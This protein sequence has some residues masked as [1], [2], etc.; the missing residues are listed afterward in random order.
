MEKI[1]PVYFDTSKQTKE[2][3]SRVLWVQELTQIH[4]V[5]MEIEHL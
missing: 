2:S 1:V 4:N 5:Q 3:L